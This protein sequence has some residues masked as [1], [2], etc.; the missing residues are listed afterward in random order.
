MID[1][2]FFSLLKVKG[3]VASLSFSI[4]LL[5]LKKPIEE[6]KANQE[7]KNTDRITSSKKKAV[8]EYKEFYIFTTN[9]FQLN[10]IFK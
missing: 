7:Y 8:S 4:T 10:P 9:T 5:V 2:S 1:L 3:A 6:I